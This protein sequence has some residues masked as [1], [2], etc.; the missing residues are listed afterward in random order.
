MLKQSVKVERP[1]KA[2]RA[3]VAINFRGLRLRNRSSCCLE[4]RKGPRRGVIR[5]GVGLDGTAV[6]GP[7]PQP[8]GLHNPQ[9]GFTAARPAANLFRAANDI[10]RCLAG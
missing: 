6:C 9:A 4:K 1:A 2:G 3:G 7:S 10:A 8:S 5:R